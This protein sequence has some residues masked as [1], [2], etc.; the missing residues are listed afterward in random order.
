MAQPPQRPTAVPQAKAGLPPQPQ[1]KSAATATVAGSGEVLVARASREYRVKRGIIVVMLIGMGLWFGYDGFIGWPKENQLIKDTK[2]QIEPARKA[3]EE[4]K[5]RELEVKLG[6][7]KEHSELDLLWQRLL[8]YSL[9]PLG[10][11]VL[12]VALYRSRGTYRLAD[13]ILHAPGHPPVPLDAIRSIDK[14]HWDRKGIAY[15]N[16]E[17]PNGA[18]GS[19]VLDDFIYQRQGTDDIFKRIEDYTGTGDV[20]VSVPANR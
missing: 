18:K 3:N 11:V 6:T 20:P 16:Y 8:C 9:P 4:A 15:V 19:V 13:N 10:L 1:A 12:G 2:A 5:V 14:T 7:L 17:L